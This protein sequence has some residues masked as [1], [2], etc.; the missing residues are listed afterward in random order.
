[1]KQTIIPKTTIF[2]KLTNY[3]LTILAPLLLLLLALLVSCNRVEVPTEF[4]ESKE[5]PAIYPD[6]VDVTVPVNIAPLTFEMKDNVA[7]MVARYSF[8][9]DEIV[10]GGD[11]AQPDID[12]WKALAEKAK[13]NA[14]KVEV[15][16]RLKD[17]GGR[18]KDETTS[19]VKEEGWIKYKPFSIY[20][21]PDSIDP[22]ISYRLISPSYVTYEE[23]T[24][25]QRCLENYDE[26]V[27][28]DNMLCGNEIN[29]QCINCHNY[30]Q[31]NPNRMQFHA[32]Q[33]HGGT[34]IAYDG[35]LHKVNMANDSILSA[36][37]YPTWHP[38][39]KLIVYSTNKT[40]QSFHTRDINKIEVLDSES[41]LIVYDVERNEVMNIENDPK[42]FEIYPFWAP[43]GKM[44]YF[45]SAHFEYSA[46]TVNTAETIQ[47]A[48]EIKYSIYRKSF[49]PET[50]EFG[51]KELVYDA[52]ANDMSATLPRISPDGRWL[53]F[54][55]G[56]W[57]CFHIW[58]RDA[59]LYMI[60]LAS[61]NSEE[62]LRVG[63]H[64]SGMGGR[65]NEERTRNEKGTVEPSS[66]LSPL[67]SFIPQPL[68]AANSNQSESYHTWSGNGRWIIFSSRRTDG[69]YTRP[70]IAHIDAEGHASKAFELPCADPDYHRQLM[71]SYNIP[72][73]MTGPVT[74][75]PQEFARVL[76]SEVE[77][78]KYTNHLKK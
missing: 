26:S 9:N 72:E 60:D 6:Y 53:L 41:D 19:N 39:L 16:A 50:R 32:R 30:Q 74:I 68:V 40:M 42:E 46:D 4:T 75:R 71:K 70:F 45:C 22:Y 31:R 10:C 36:G 8:G 29:G 69:V 33:F 57:G 48:E 54:T 27:I 67:S 12:D 76:K 11:K 15:F 1:M 64:G 51:P 3:Y 28:Y 13:G 24:I 61:L 25:N 49:N 35:D 2:D 34:M 62:R 37:V 14:I 17:D 20:V 52:A 78:V 58:H 56:G 47:R 63:E 44:L 55:M 5:L 38:W 65:R 59:D 23:L 7:E 21:S 66:L 43:D 18:L 77:P 73:F